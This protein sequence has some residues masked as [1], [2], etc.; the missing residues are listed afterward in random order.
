MRGFILFIAISQ[1]ISGFFSSAFALE[2]RITKSLRQL[3]R[4]HALFVKTRISDHDPLWVQVRSGRKSGTEAC[5]ELLAEARITASGTIAVQTDSDEPTRG[6]RILS[7]FLE[8]RNATFS[9]RDFNSILGTDTNEN[10]HDLHSPA[11]HFLYSEFKEGE[12]YDGAITRSFD[13]RAKRFSRFPS[14]PGS[15]R[16]KVSDLSKP[17]WIAKTNSNNPNP[18]TF[19]GNHPGEDVLWN[20][21]LNA[22]KTT[23]DLLWSPIW[24]E[25]GILNGLAP[26]T[27]LNRV[28]V[29]NSVMR[30][31]AYTSMHYYDENASAHFGAGFIGTQAYLLKNI[32]QRLDELENRGNGGSRLP[33]DFMKN[34]ISDVLCRPIPVLRSGDA[35]RSGAVKSDSRL[36]WVKADS[37]MGC[38]YT[39]DPAMGAFRN[40]VH[41]R[42]TEGNKTKAYQLYF[43]AKKQ[44]V[45][46]SP[47]PLPLFEDDEKFS[48]RPPDFKLKFRS[49]DGTLVDLSGTGLPEF[50]QKI[51]ETKDF[52]ACGAKRY[53]EWL[54]GIQVDLS[55][56]QDPL[57]P[58]VLSL[59]QKRARDQVISLGEKL[60]DTQSAF[61]VIREILDSDAFLEGSVP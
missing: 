36:P 32:E 11:Y 42:S 49:Y 21:V 12:R 13:L 34:L 59:P 15:T 47:G 39:L 61:Q 29:I 56:L 16:Q 57:N 31:G 10:V 8:F 45:T 46:E 43:M 26:S 40:F 14:A 60:K 52:Y 33:R 22:S 4:C 1:L 24:V 55:D 53:Y 54:T 51:S 48:D 35:I 41:V 19:L 20:G 3:N 44:L 17:V 58:V 9:A 37:C 28:Q 5:M 25:L 2:A 50:G 6:S 18:R 38:H 7:S 23:Q 27:V 30:N